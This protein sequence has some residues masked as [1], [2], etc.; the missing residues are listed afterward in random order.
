MSGDPFY[1]DIWIKVFGYLPP[2]DIL[3]SASLISTAHRAH[4]VEA[5][6]SLDVTKYENIT[7]AA[8]AKIAKLT[9]LTSLDAG[10][11]DKITDAE[12]AEI[13]KLTAL[14]SLDR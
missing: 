1:G 14:T 11:C 2:R 4:S 12:V 6:T 3:M 10:G 7:D 13:S 9:A 8:F 5:L